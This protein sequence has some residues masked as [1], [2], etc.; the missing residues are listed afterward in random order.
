MNNV[1]FDSIDM[2]SQFNAVLNE[3]EIKMPS[4]KKQIINVPGRDGEIDLSEFTGRLCYENRDIKMKFTLLNKKNIMQ[5]ASDI[6]D[7]LHSRRVKIIFSDDSDYYYV[8]RLSVETFKLDR[9]L[10]VITISAD[11]EPWKYKKTVTKKVF[12]VAG[13][14][15]VTCENLNRAIMP[16]IT[17]TA[18]VQIEMNSISVNIS[19]GAR[20]YDGIVF[21]KGN[22]Q[23]KLTGTAKVTFEYQE[24]RL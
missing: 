4:I 1:Y 19:A 12:D 14:K 5:Q 8:G 7:A 16:L 17:T 21:R 13:T 20:Y 2:F 9:N 11:C 22:N 6:F 24:A 18:P 10:G 15:T 3:K 23:L